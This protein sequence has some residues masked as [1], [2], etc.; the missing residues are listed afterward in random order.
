MVERDPRGAAP[1]PEKHIRRAGS[2][3]V[4]ARER[5][6]WFYN[7]IGNLSLW[8]GY[9][10]PEEPRFFD[11]AIRDL[12]QAVER[13]PAYQPREN[14]ADAYAY[15]ARHTSDP[16]EREKLLQRAE[17]LYRQAND[18]ARSLPPG[19]QE[20]VE[21]RLIVS[22]AVAQL[23]L[24]SRPTVSRALETISSLDSEDAQPA[25][26]SIADRATVYNIASCYALLDRLTRPS[27]GRPWILA[28]PSER[29]LVHPHAR[30][31]QYLAYALIAWPDA[32][33]FVPIDPD[34]ASLPGRDSLLDSLADRSDSGLTGTEADAETKA[35]W[36][37]QATIVMAEIEE[38]LH[39]T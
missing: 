36:W 18:F 24:E 11:D 7:Y 13:L 32:R 35:T 20:Q 29:L 30:A 17:R 39:G 37:S 22:V 21:L 33:R 12:R 2:G 3:N 1:H 14:L 6:G 10:Y 34:L 31:L 8:S 27:P 9:E 26:L 38:D 25:V 16:R 4:K 15:K 19:A 23:L 28:D 5:A